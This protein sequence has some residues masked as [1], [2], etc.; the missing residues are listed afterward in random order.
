[1]IRI[2]RINTDKTITPSLQRMKQ[3]P[4]AI[5]LCS[6]FFILHST[7]SIAQS[8]TR[9]DI[10]A[11]TADTLYPAPAEAHKILL[12]PF[13]SK[14]CMSQID[15]DINKTT[16]LDF[17][18][19][20]EAFRKGLDLAMYSRLHQSYVTLSLLQGRYKSDSVLNYIY[21]ST[22]YNYELVPGTK[23]DVDDNSNNS[24]KN[25]YVVQGQL[26]VPV[27]YSKRFMDVALK[28]KEMLPFLYRKYHTD[29]FVFINELDIKNVP[30]PSGDL[31]D[32]NAYVREV[33]VHYSILY[34][35]GASIAKGIATTGF[36]YTE[37][38]PADIRDKYFTDIARSIMSDYV[39]GIKKEPAGEKGK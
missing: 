23:A 8:N 20:T 25:H 12:V 9:G 31:S 39:K 30:N 38:T 19:I 17:D 35:N 16:H 24:Q 36:P 29:T 2:L 26:Q 1:M 11:H 7:L 13:Y 15:R 27:D 37:N 32:D 21:G 33:T 14:M 5:V 3:T 34:K 10:D 4:F 22:G 18:H 6:S 28:N